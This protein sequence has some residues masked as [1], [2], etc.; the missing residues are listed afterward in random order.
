[1]QICLVMRND[2]KLDEN[3]S[4]TFREKKNILGATTVDSQLARYSCPCPYFFLPFL[5]L[6]KF[7]YKLRAKNVHFAATA[8]SLY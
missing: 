4:N 2:C 7:W 6:E 3:I 1:M 8:E 5:L